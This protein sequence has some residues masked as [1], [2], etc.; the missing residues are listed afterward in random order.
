MLVLALLP[1]L[2]LVTLAALKL[3][4]L[5]ATLTAQKVATLFGAGDGAV[6]ATEVGDSRSA[7]VGD[8]V[9]NANGAEGGHSLSRSRNESHACGVDVQF[10]LARTQS[11]PAPYLVQST[12]ADVAHM[13]GPQYRMTWHRRTRTPRESCGAIC[14]D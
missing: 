11:L 4:S 9:G 2:K 12:D 3:A 6:A 8:T 13:P 10:A 5:S 1:P 7:E 14:N